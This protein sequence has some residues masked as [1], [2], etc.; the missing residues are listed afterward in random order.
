MPE[1]VFNLCFHGIG[2]PPRDISPG[3]AEYWL[4][5]DRFYAILDALHGRADIRLSFDDGN[6]SDV[7]LAMPALLERNLDATFF[8]VADR[9]G[10]LGFVDREGV[11][12]LVANGFSIGCHGMIHQPWRGLS[13]DELNAELV[14]ARDVLADA[15]GVA[16]TEAAFPFGAYDRHALAAV[17]GAGY[18]RAFTSDGGSATPDA[19]VQTRVLARRADDAHLIDKLAPGMRNGP[20]REAK[21]LVKRWR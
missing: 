3:E 11:S 8:L 10:K 18:E 7:L 13:A 19:W 14:T 17:R 9:L 21:M 12:S 20:I 16:I 15:A 5:I 2:E 1:R 4:D 6:G